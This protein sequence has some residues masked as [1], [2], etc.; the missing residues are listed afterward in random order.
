MKAKEGP[1]RVVS[2]WCG[3]TVGPE[4]A[5]GI[6]SKGQVSSQAGAKVLVIRHVH[7]QYLGTI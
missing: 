1:E 6:G 3:T 5:T 2:L 7:V 4:L